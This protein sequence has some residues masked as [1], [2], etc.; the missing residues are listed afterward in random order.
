DKKQIQ[1]IFL[2]EFK[3]GHKAAETTRNIN[4][5]GPG[6]AN[7]CTLW[8]WCRKFCKGDK[9]LE[10]EKYSSQ[11]LEVDSDQWRLNVDHATVVR[12]LKQIG[13]AKNLSKWV[14]LEMTKNQ[15][16]CHFEVLS[17]LILCNNNEPFF[18][19]TLSGW[20]Q[21]QLQS[22]SQSHTCTK[23]SSLNP[24]ETITSEKSVQQTDEITGL[25]LLH[26]NEVLLHP[27]CSPDFL[28]TNYHIFKH[29][30]NFL[31][32]KCFHNQ[33]EVEN[34]SQEFTESQS[35]DFYATG[36]NKLISCWQKCINCNRSYFD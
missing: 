12:H 5:C 7:K 32:G 21:K 2:F 36:K 17:F 1:A 6:A 34:A 19:W 3:M 35:M 16:N 13:K 22:S 31:Q 4:T 20:A 24:S 26:D 11:P 10:D 25:I 14:P 15:K 9:S 8:W 27:P 29:P 30:D 33:Q 23:K 18:D 28:P